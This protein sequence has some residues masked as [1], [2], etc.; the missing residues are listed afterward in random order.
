MNTGGA[1]AS[2]ILDLINI[3]QLRVKDEFGVE[4]ETEV[5]IEGEL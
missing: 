1:T 4:L 2:D 5:K 3:V